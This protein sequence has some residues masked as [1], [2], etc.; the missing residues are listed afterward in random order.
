MMVKLC[1]CYRKKSVIVSF[2]LKKENTQF[3]T[4]PFP[5]SPDGYHPATQ[6]ER[7]E[8]QHK[9]PS[10]EKLHS[11]IYRRPMDTFYQLLCLEPDQICLLARFSNHIRDLLLDDSRSPDVMER[12]RLTKLVTSAADFTRNLSHDHIAS[13]SK[14]YSLILAVSVRSRGL[15]LLPQL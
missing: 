11:A 1:S 13:L 8:G 5:L 9:L 7:D 6:I 12:A 2:L 15:S 14:L 4:Y 10:V 3:L